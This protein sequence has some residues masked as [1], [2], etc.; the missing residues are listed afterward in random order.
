MR[1]YI[2]ASEEFDEEFD[3]DATNYWSDFIDD[4]PPEPIVFIN[5]ARDGYAPDQIIDD[6]ITVGELIDMLSDYNPAEKVMLINDNGYTFG[7]IDDGSIF[8]GDIT[9]EWDIHR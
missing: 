3:P 2:K 4:T 5:G 9:Q 7:I 8:E 1:K 6:T